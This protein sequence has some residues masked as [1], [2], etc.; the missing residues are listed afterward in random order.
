VN[1][2]II[3]TQFAEAVVQL[4]LQHELIERYYLRRV[5]LPGSL[6]INYPDDAVCQALTLWLHL[7]VGCGLISNYRFESSY[8]KLP[9]T[10]FE[11]AERIRSLGRAFGQTLGQL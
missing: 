10:A 11:A 3:T 7:A 9:E 8:E 6:E 1:K 5:L 2:L 4:L